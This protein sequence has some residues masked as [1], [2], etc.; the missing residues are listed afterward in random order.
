MKKNRRGF[1]LVEL[2]AVIALLAVVLTIASLSIISIQGKIKESQKEKLISSMKVSAEKYVEETGLKKVYVD[3]L[4]KEG[5]LAADKVDDSGEKVI[6]NP[7]DETS[8]NCYYYDFTDK[9]NNFKPGNC[10]PNLVSDQ[11]L[12]IRYCEIR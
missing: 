4:I 12:Y 7:V 8:L 3:T 2:L 6:L 1:T 11:V 10:N 5:Y 9:E